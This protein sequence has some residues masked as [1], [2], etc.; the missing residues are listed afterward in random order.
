MNLIVDVRLAGLKPTIYCQKSV[1]VSVKAIVLRISACHDEKN[2]WSSGSTKYEELIFFFFFNL[3]TLPEV[4]SC[5]YYKC[6]EY[7]LSNQNVLLDCLQILVS[8]SKGAQT[9]Q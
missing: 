8:F 9:S 7:W 1:I 2:Q 4:T 6:L 3:E 5:K